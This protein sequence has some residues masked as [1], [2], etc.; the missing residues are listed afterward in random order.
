MTQFSKVEAGKITAFVEANCRQVA[1]PLRQ[2]KLRSLI[3]HNFFWQGHHYIG[4]RVSGNGQVNWA[5]VSDVFNAQDD[6][7]RRAY[8]NSLNF[9]K[10]DAKKLIGILGRTPNATVTAVNQRDD[11]QV[12]CAED[13]QQILE[14]LRWHW[15]VEALN[16]YLV[17][18]L[19]T[20]GPAYGYTPFG[21]DGRKFGKT[22][23]PKF[24]NESI[25]V[26]PGVFEDIPVTDGYDEFDN[27]AVSLIIATDYQVTKPP[28]IKSIEDA[29]WLVFEREVDK[30]SVLSTYPEAKQR[31]KE[32]GSQAG[33]DTMGRTARDASASPV[34]YSRPTTKGYW[35]ETLVWLKP[36]MYD[37]MEVD[38]AGDEGTAARWRREHPDGVKLVIVEGTLLREESENLDDVWFECPAEVGHSLDEPALGDET[39]RLNRAIDDTFNVVTEVAEKGSPV[40]LYDA[41]VIDPLAIHQHSKNPVDWIPVTS[42]AGGDI[43]KGIW[44]SEPV[45]V[46]PASLQLL[47]MA[48][49]AM[50]ENSGVTPALWGGETKQ[51][52][53]GEA[54]INRNM[55]L[56]PHNV[57]WNFMRRFWSGVFTNGIRQTARFNYSKAYFGGGRGKPVRELEMPKMRALLNGNWEVETEEAIPQTWGQKRAQTIQ[58]LDRGPELWSMFGMGDPRNVKSLLKTMGNTAFVLPGEKQRDKTLADI[59][60]LLREQPVMPQMPGQPPMSSRPADQFEDDHQ[61]VVQI[62]REWAID[63][64]GRQAR[65]ENPQGYMNVILWAQEHASMVPPPPEAMGPDGAPPPGAEAPPPQTDIGSMPPAGIDPS[66]PLVPEELAGLALE[67]A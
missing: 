2:A 67:G 6:E 62:V 19:W 63:Q 35:T 44:E 22:Q 49:N 57:T 41:E 48:K 46:A 45:E 16:A 26:E 29:N 61:L 38:G 15:D 9:Y 52:T 28:R 10:G 37:L 13:A 54:E 56:L 36:A 42:G 39:A 40:I 65:A 7:G 24:R 21:V 8:F 58:I 47:D 53:L 17:F 11:D 34:P 66:S 55:A 50:R 60:V 31:Y 5:P 33:G 51:Q 25:E 27:G 30:A 4:P 1:S 20:C 14:N 43:K 3:R 23:I 12:S 64:P 59:A 18:C 32:I